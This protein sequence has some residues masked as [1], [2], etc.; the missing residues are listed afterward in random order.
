MDCV[1][2]A[3]FATAGDRPSMLHLVWEGR[4]TVP[5]LPGLLIVGLVL[6]GAC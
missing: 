5:Q 6:S 3:D 4:A 2:A 1:G